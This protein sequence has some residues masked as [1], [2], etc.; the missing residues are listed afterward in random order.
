MLKK[1]HAAIEEIAPIHG[2]SMPNPEDK[3]SWVV[4][5]KDEA[6]A[7]Q[8]ADAQAVIDDLDVVALAASEDARAKRRREYGN[9][10][11][12]LDDAMKLIKILM[13][14]AG[15]PDPT[16]RLAKRDAVK[17]AHPKP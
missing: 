10:A 9:V 15:I 4:N 2:I 1:I 5:F 7:Q 13:D 3:T 6:T 8:K 17:A 16:G 12:N 11:D 14:N